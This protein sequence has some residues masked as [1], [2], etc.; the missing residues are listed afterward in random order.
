RRRRYLRFPR[1]TAISDDAQLFDRSGHE[2]IVAVRVRMLRHSQQMVAGWD[3]FADLDF[4]L[5]EHLDQAG[6]VYASLAGYSIT[7]FKTIRSPGNSH[8]VL[9]VA[10]TWRRDS[11]QY[12]R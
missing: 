8:T 11:D 6:L 3:R 9:A 5:S 4:F 10:D 12:D 2:C 7:D 1:P